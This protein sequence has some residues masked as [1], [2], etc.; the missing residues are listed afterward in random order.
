MISL[1]CLSSTDEKKQLTACYKKM[2]LLSR[3]ITFYSSGPRVLSFPVTLFY[4]SYRAILLLLLTI[5]TINIVV[6]QT[7]AIPDP[8]FEQALIDLGLDSGPIDGTVLTA[9]VSSASYLDVSNRGIG[10][11]SGIES[12]VALQN[13]WCEWNTISWLD[14]SFCPNIITVHCGG[15]NMG[16]IYL[17][18]C[19]NL[20]SISAWGNTFSSDPLLYHPWLVYV[21]LTGSSIW[22]IDLSDYPKLKIVFL[23]NCSLNSL[24]LGVNPT[25]IEEFDISSNPGISVDMSLLPNLERFWCNGNNLTTLDVTN[26]VSLYQLSASS[27]DL[28][29]LDLSFNPV[30]QNIYIPGNN[31]SYLDLRN[32]NNSGIYMFNASSNSNLKCILVDDP[33]ESTLNWTFSVGAA[34]YVGIPC[35]KKITGTIYHDINVDCIEDVGEE[36]IPNVL[37]KAAGPNQY[38][39]LTDNNGYYELWVDTNTTYT[40]EAFTPERD[41]IEVSSCPSAGYVVNSGVGSSDI[42]NKDFAIELKPCALL[43]VDI[44]SGGLRRCASNNLTLAYS[45]VGALYAANVDLFIDFPEYVNLVSASKT[46]VVVDPVEKIYK[47][48]FDTIHPLTY[49]EISIINSVICFNSGIRGY[50][51]CIKSWITPVTHCGDDTDTTNWDRSHIIIESTPK[52]VGDTIVKFTIV[53]AGSG[54]MTVSRDYRIYKN[55]LVAYTGSFMLPSGDSLMVNVNVDGTTIRLE[56]DQDSL[57]PGDSKPRATIEGCGTSPVNLGYW[58]LA[59]TDD[60][61]PETTEVC[62][63][64]RDSY[65]PNDKRVHPGGITASGYVSETDP[66][67]YTIR[68]QN[69]GTISAIDII[70]VDTL[71]SN[72][73]LSTLNV[74]GASHSFTYEITGM[75]AHVLAF[76]FDNINLPDSTSDEPGS[77][78]YVSFSMEPDSLIV[79]GTLIENTTDIYFDFNVAVRT[80]TAIVVALDIEVPSTLNVTVTETGC[81]TLADNG[82][83]SN[84]SCSGGSDGNISSVPYGGL[85]NIYTYIWSNGS[86]NSSITGLSIGSY[87]VTISQSICSI[88]VGYNVSEPSVFVATAS[89]DVN[90]L[91]YGSTD[92]GATVSALGGATPYAYSWSNTATT[93]SIINVIAGLYYVTATDANSC[94][95]IAVVN[96]TEPFLITGTDVIIACDSLQWIDGITYTTSNNSATVT[97]TNAVG[98]DSVVTLDLTINYSSSGTDVITACDSYTWIDGNTYTTSNNSATITLTNAAGCDGIATLDLTINYSSSGTDVITACD[99]YTWIDGNTY[100]TSNNSTTFTLT[101]AAGCDSVVT[102]DLTINNSSTGTDVITACDSYTW[103]DGNTYTSNNNN[104]TQVLTNAAGCDSLVTLNLTINSIFNSSESTTICSGDNYTFPDGTTQSNIATAIAYTST[105]QTVN[106]CDSIIVTTVNIGSSQT[107][108]TAT[109]CSGDNYT[110]PDGS[111][112]TNL[113]AQVIYTSNLQ[114]VLGCD[115]T[116]VTTVNI[117]P[118][119]NLTDT[120]AICSGESFTFPDGT[121]LS[122]ITS[123]YTYTSNLQSAFSCDSIITTTVNPTKNSQSDSISICFG[124]SYTFPDGNVLTD[125]TSGI[126]YTSIIQAPNACD[127]LIVTTISI[128]EVDTTI[129]LSGDSLIA[130]TSNALYQWIDCGTLLPIPGAENQL[131]VA[132]TS[133]NYAVEINQDGCINVSSCYNILLLKIISNEF[134][135]ALSVYPNPIMDGLYID[136]R[137]THEKIIVSIS[138]MQGQEVFNSIYS[139]QQLISID[140]ETLSSGTYFIKLRNQN[141]QIATFKFIKL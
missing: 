5:F 75:D 47:F 48:S 53:N 108:E 80:D 99:S 89:V 122:N 112:Q 43:S 12:F 104:S 78:G 70:V 81:T 130:N 40:I 120:I 8:N 135:S 102:L 91:C 6:A 126:V 4:G 100:T 11:L 10:S 66:L 35:N 7:T 101:N 34:E 71:S 96:I 17:A 139:K 62:M 83:V 137:N 76:S 36:P 55:N 33:W 15:N 93:L 27:N 138:G 79:P 28:T 94:D 84:V 22:D 54:D 14:L 111:T 63:I 56:A 23:S 57:H 128:T 46:Y 98:C 38:N 61:D 32:G 121:S 97:L 117:A 68:F 49:G 114:S 74:I 19:S 3:L 103:I 13:L 73:D 123:S 24:S 115:S 88:T 52:C 116:I 129:I 1:I 90:V 37:V 86:T 105:L 31:L 133:G 134:G 29:T 92:G 60:L 106:G 30:M 2:K 25:L 18:G 136:F 125:I 113:T 67:N 65:D 64:I 140:L 82:S 127:S 124:T 59:P 50:T 77:H 72:L 119:Y 118:D 110:F 21:D 69:T 51:Q 131:F 26:N 45:N 87:Q 41:R 132:N 9:N 39:T 42:L 20:I 44:A 58:P 95:S 141:Q 109:I 85:A 16:G 107:T